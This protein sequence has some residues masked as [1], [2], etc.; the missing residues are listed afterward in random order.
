MVAQQR[1]METIRASLSE[2]LV[3]KLPDA[4]DVRLSS[5]TKPGAGFSNETLLADLA[6]RERGEE[7]AE[8]LVFRLEPRDVRVFPEYDLAR[9]VRVMRCLI[10]TGIAVPTVRWLE[11]DQGVVGR[12]FYVMDRIEGEVPPDVPFYHTTG[13][14]ADATPDAREEMWW[15]GVETLARIHSVDWQ[16][17]G[18]SFLRVP[19]A[20]TD[21][22]DRQIDYYESF[23][24]WA[25]QDE[26]EPVLD[27]ALRWLRE[28]RFT[29][30]RV[31]LCWGDARLP[32]I[33][34][35]DNDVAGALDWEMAFLGDPE[36]DL[37]WWLFLDWHH[38][39]GHGVARLPGLP[40]RNE[41][42]C[43]YEEL[44]ARKTEHLFYHEVMAG[45]RF[46]VIM[47]SLYRQ[48]RRLSAPA[49]SPGNGLDS[50]ITRRL[51]ALLDI[52]FQAS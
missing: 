3:G 33:I 50:P 11:E 46:G 36:A 9:Q 18:L 35:R 29:P 5:L 14:L 15:R 30:A 10:D 6:W 13:V 41:T 44:T 12:A 43:R 31:A 23:L 34:F 26:P 19:G 51:A 38:S 17:L 2:W 28:H 21:P 49:Q 37:A 42:V 16:A 4:D 22:L 8:R 39:E 7:R 47:V 25:Q 40:D 1:D 32:N 24:R 52:P 45:L 20:G 48:L 27:A